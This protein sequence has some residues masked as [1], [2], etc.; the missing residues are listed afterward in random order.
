MC[1]R[2]PNPDN[3]DAIGDYK[4][5]AGFSAS[6]V[7]DFQRVVACIELQNAAGKPDATLDTTYLAAVGAATFSSKIVAAMS[8]HAE[9]R[10]GALFCDVA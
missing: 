4:N 10:P 7:V 5:G 9:W 8:S 2:L 3:V 6:L 1:P